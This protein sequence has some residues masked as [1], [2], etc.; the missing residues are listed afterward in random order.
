[1]KRT[2]VAYADVP[3]LL[4]KAVLATEDE[5]FFEHP[6]IDYR[7]V[8][9]G[10]IAELG[11]GPE[12]GGSTITQQVPRHAR[13]DE[14]SGTELRLRPVRREVQG[15]D[16]RVSHG[17]GVHEGRDPRALLEYELLRPALVWHRDGGADLFRQVARRALRF[18][19]RDSRRHSATADAVEPRVQ[20]GAR[21]HAAR[22]RAAAHARD[23]RDRRPTSTKRRWWNPSSARSSVSRGSSTRPTSPRWCEREMVRRFGYAAHDGRAS[24]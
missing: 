8:I 5:H 17:A 3:P 6:G 12:V 11:I 22:L 20:H 10:F 18:G 4:I 1:M 9:R 13:G 15:V 16:P 2:P 24:R 14:A 21:G 7:G 23:S 19:D